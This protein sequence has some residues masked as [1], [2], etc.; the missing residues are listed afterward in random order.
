MTS[1]MV[2]TSQRLASEAG[3]VILREGGNAADA[4]VAAAAA[5]NL[6]EPM[7]TGLGGDMFALFYDARTK[8]ITA[9][10]GSGRAPAALSIELLRKQGLDPLPAHHAHAVTVPGACAG[11][12][13]LIARHGTLPLSRI[14]APAVRM[15]EEGFPVAPMTA[16]GWAGG[17][18]MLKGPGE[19]DL[20]IDGRAPR[21]GET[22]RNVSLA[23]TF[24]AVASGGKDAY[25]KG[26][27]GR[28]V[29]AALRAAGGVM[30]AED[31]ET[32]ESTWVDPIHT[33][34]R[35]MGVWECPPNG[36]GITALLALNI[37]EGFDLKGQDPA[38]AERW[39]LLIE[40]MR[41]AFA[42]ARWYVADPQVSKVP[43]AE[44]LSKDYAAKRR[45]L[46][47]PKR[48][49]VDVRHG[50]PVAGS[51]TVYFCVVDGSGNACSFINS[52]YMGFGTG[53]VPA[54]C[55]FSLQNRDACFMTDP[56]HPN[57]LAP[58]K[59]P[60]HTI[61]PGMLTRADGTLYAP[62]GVMGGFMQ[63]QGHVQVVV[64]IVDDGLEPQPVLDRPRFCIQPVDGAESRVHL[65]AG[66]PPATVAALRERGHLL[67]P[68]V[69][70]FAR[71]LFGRG[72]VIRRDPDGSLTGGSD[73]R[74]DGCAKSA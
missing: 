46:F 14:L 9:L 7:S 4:A 32:H 2:A 37:L 57:A 64:G 60:Y 30:T 13:D 11:W 39:H 43:S 67:V 16:H 74:A 56:S 12:C 41:I 20:T 10:N 8:K 66:L 18:S 22:F 28:A 48:A 1:G 47:D 51:D 58:R 5:L 36:Q 61:I 45:A 27:P 17:R 23:R 26:E 6:T 33:T 21:E 59:R 54:G 63:P 40:V 42:D 68:G 19:R 25:Y 31:L 38:G 49:S 15:A 53:I 24:R 55:G 3:V 52:N 71:A 35:G 72:Q 69:S 50:S 29:I 34:Y 65:E 44:L 73:P 62:F 70:G